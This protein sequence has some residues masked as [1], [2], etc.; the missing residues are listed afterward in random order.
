MKHKIITYLILFFLCNC[1]NNNYNKATE[2]SI[3]TMHEEVIEETVESFLNESITNPGNYE[4][5]FSKENNLSNINNPTPFIE[6]T[7]SNIS[8]KN[9]NSPQN[10]FLVKIIYVQGVLEKFDKE[11]NDFISLKNNDEISPKNEIQL[12]NNSVAVLRLGDSKYIDINGPIARTKAQN[13]FDFYANNKGDKDKSIWNKMLEILDYSSNEGFGELSGVTRGNGMILDENKSDFYISDQVKVL[14]ENDA[15]I[16]WQ[17]VKNYSSNY[18]L[19]ISY[20]DNK[21]FKTIDTIFLTKDT[22]LLIRK[23]IIN[24]CNPCEVEIINP[25]NSYNSSKIKLF[26]INYIDDNLKNQLYLIDNLII[27]FPNIKLYQYAKIQLLIQNEYFAT[28]HLLFKEY[29]AE[30]NLNT[31]DYNNFLKAIYKNYYN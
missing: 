21:E 27:D 16:F 15:F 23:E 8:Y 30:N 4:S 17:P 13:L 26:S 28:A 25:Q 10:N 6:D 9:N 19:K 22:S 20:L 24:K 1:S 5:K 12:Q 31:D 2:T 11:K 14:K 7:F 3:H 18:K 29:I